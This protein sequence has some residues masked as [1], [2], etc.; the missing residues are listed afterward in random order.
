MNTNIEEKITARCGG[1][2]YVLTMEEK[3]ESGYREIGL[4]YEDGKAKFVDL[5]LAET[6]EFNVNNDVHRWAKESFLESIK[7]YKKIKRQELEQIEAVVREC[8]VK[9]AKEKPEGEKDE[10]KSK[11][12]ENEC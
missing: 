2:L 5:R 1:I 11:E 9:Q 10:P 4:L 6:V 8:I 12:S 3:T 7:T